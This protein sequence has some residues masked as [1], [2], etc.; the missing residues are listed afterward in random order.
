MCCDNNDGNVW[1]VFLQVLFAYLAFG[2]VN[3]HFPKSFWQAFKDYDGQPGKR[4]P[5]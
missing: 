1:V 5:I 3:H 4:L 2:K